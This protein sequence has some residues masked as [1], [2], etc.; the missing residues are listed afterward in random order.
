MPSQIV[1]SPQ[2]FLV[3]LSG[4][5]SLGETMRFLKALIPAILAATAL[6][7]CTPALTP[8]AVSVS[9]ATITS[10]VV[11][12]STASVQVEVALKDK[13]NGESYDVVLLDLGSDANAEITSF[14]GKGE[15]VAPI[16]FVVEA[17]L[18]EV[19]VELR[20]KSGEVLAE[21]SIVQITA[22]DPKVVEVA[23]K[24]PPKKWLINNPISF[25]VESNFDLQTPGSE[26]ILESLESNK[27]QKVSAFDADLNLIEEV[28]SPS[29]VKKQ[30]RLS[31]LLS[32]QLLKSSEG[33][34]VFFQS[35]ESMLASLAYDS[36]Q[37]ADNGSKASWDF[38]K[39]STY[40]NLYDFAGADESIEREWFR[41][42]LRE[43]FVVVSGT[44]RPDPSWILTT[45]S[46]QINFLGET[47]P[48]ETF[49]FDSEWFFADQFNN[50]Y[51][52]KKVSIHGTFIDGKMWLYLPPCN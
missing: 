14:E 30:F 35:A 8:G 12:G 52:P 11:A 24:K 43:H 42:G 31:I 26:V 38:R 45:S 44:V 4:Q 33:F 49:I 10:H 17:G 3:V 5:S 48:G 19:S 27:W 39:S 23:F 46:C 2:L 21:S 13:S 9:L 47:P 29:E 51:D 22:V 18:S 25:K 34:D 1:F 28:Q 15:L 36:Q 16:D 32:G 20:N 37:A 7:G 40:P 6:T 50:R 41:Y